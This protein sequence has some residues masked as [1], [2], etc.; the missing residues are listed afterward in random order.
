MSHNFRIILDFIWD[1]L[2]QNQPH[3]IIL[4]QFFFKLSDF[5]PQSNPKLPKGKTIKYLFFQ[6]VFFKNEKIKISAD[7]F[8]RP[9]PK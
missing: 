8:Q 5:P 7:F 3:R 2:P 6:I 9:M 4:A 1:V